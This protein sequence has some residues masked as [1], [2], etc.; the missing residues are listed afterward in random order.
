MSSSVLRLRPT[1]FKH[2]IVPTACHKLKAYA[3]VQFLWIRE[4]ALG[5]ARK[6][7]YAVRSVGE[8][9]VSVNSIELVNQF[10]K[11]RTTPPQLLWDLGR[12]YAWKDGLSR[13]PH[14]ELYG[15]RQDGIVHRD[16][17]ETKTF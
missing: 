15:G 9:H 12:A 3:A 7:V 11:G 5:T 14:D 1:C 4:K 16:E 13:V 17:Q 10:V 6:R 8:L 2:S